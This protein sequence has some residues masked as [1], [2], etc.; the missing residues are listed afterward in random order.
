MTPRDGGPWRGIDAATW[1]ERIARNSTPKSE[2]VDGSFVPWIGPA[3]PWINP[4]PR[5]A[6]S[7]PDPVSPRTVSAGSEPAPGRLRDRPS[8]TPPG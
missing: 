8:G 6:G 2:Y 4:D 5:G 7:I 1:V 3:S